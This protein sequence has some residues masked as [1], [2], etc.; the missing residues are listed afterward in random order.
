MAA[1][2]SG[3]SPFQEQRRL[4]GDSHHRLALRP[5]RQVAKLS[6]EFGARR[7][8]GG[9]MGGRSGLVLSSFPTRHVV[10]GRGT[11]GEQ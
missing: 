11:M 2:S 9:V 5:A 1:S 3:T 7:P 10:F 4:L 6:D 8:I